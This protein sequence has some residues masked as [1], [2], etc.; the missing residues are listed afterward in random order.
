MGVTVRIFRHE[1]IIADQERRDHRAGGNVEGLK[2]EG[3]DDERNDQRMD[4][5]AHRLGKASLLSFGS[6]LHAHSP[7]IL[8]SLSPTRPAPLYPLGWIGAIARGD[9]SRRVH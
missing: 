5:D 8:P 1:Q 9:W 2:Q 4:N 6:S 3:A 7:I